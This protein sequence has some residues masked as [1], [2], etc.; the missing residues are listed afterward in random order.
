MDRGQVSVEGAVQLVA[1]SKIGWLRGIGRI[2]APKALK[3]E[4]VRQ[5]PEGRMWPNQRRTY[6]PL[7]RSYPASN[8]EDP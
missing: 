7:P 1:G 8:T 6:D 4:W 2:I 5:N 3:S